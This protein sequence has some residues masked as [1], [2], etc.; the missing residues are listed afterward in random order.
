RPPTFN[1]FRGVMTG[2][3]NSP[4]MHCGAWVFCGSS[5]ARYQ[6]W[7]TNALR[8]TVENRDPEE[9]IVFVNAWNEW[10]EGA[11]LEPCSIFGDGYLK[12]TA[13]ALSSFE[14]WP[15]DLVRDDT[16]Q[17]DGTHNR[18]IE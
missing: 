10:G 3:D 7:L 14:A 13:A 6:D 2:F 8:D 5:P 11:I 17:D 15:Q 12:A 9:Q 4:K 16:N 18:K 1:R